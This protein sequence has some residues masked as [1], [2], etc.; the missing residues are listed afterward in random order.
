MPETV[1]SSSKTQKHEPNERVFI[2]LLISLVLKRKR[3]QWSH[4]SG[5]ALLEFRNCG[6]AFFSLWCSLCILFLQFYNKKVALVK[7]PSC[8]VSRGPLVLGIDEEV[9]V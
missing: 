8:L 2:M 5:L 6:R 9:P 1:F 3:L 4:C 7:L